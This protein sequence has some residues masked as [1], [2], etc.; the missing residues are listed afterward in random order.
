MEG[1]GRGRKEMIPDAAERRRGLSAEKGRGLLGT[2][3]A[4]FSCG[5]VKR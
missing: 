4:W 3:A 1:S 2:E 5:F